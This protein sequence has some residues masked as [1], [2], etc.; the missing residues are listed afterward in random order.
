MKRQYIVAVLIFSAALVLVATYSLLTNPTASTTPIYGYRIVNTYPHAT[1][2][3][4][5][6]L[7]YSGGFLY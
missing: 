1:D 7:V 5:E 3:F 6:G 2:A 4:T